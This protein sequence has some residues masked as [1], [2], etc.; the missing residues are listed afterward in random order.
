MILRTSWSNEYTMD[1]YMHGL[2]NVKLPS[3]LWFN[4]IVYGTVLATLLLI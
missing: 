1:Q 3:A 2:L 4:D